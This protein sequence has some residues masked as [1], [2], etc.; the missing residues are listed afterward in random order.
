M[1]RPGTPSTKTT[2][3]RSHREDVLSFLDNLDSFEGSGNPSKDPASATASSSS[4]GGAASKA[5]GSSSK[6]QSS[7]VAAPSSTAGANSGE[8][9]DDPQAVLDFL[10]EIVANR[11]NRR[12]TTPSNNPA[13]SSTSTSKKAAS[14]GIAGTSGV[15]RSGSRN[16]LRDGE[17]SSSVGVT[18][19]R[20]A[21][22]STAAAAAPPRK[23]GESTRSLNTLNMTAASH[24][25]TAGQAAEKLQEAPVPESSA[26]AEEPKAGGWGWGSVWSQAS[27]VLQQARTVAEEQAKHLP[28]NLPTSISN[29]QSQLPVTPSVATSQ[30]QAGVNAATAQAQKWRSGMMNMLSNQLDI[31]KLRREITETGMKAMQ[32][33]MNAVAPPIAEHEVIQVNLSHDMLGYEGVETLVY[34][35]LAKVMEQVEGGDLVVNKGHVDDSPTAAPRQSAPA[36]EAGGE[37]E[38]EDER[39]L[40]TVEGLVEGYKLAEANLEALIKKHYKKPE[41]PS[42]ASSEKAAGHSRKESSLTIPVTICPVYMRIQPVLAPMPFSP[43]ALS[44]T[45]EADATSK[46]KTSDDL[47]LFFILILRDPTNELVHKTLTQS[48]PSKWLDIPFEENEWVEDIM[49]DVIRRG[50]EI[51]GE[52]YIKGRMHG[53]LFKNA[54]A[55]TVS[56][57]SEETEEEKEQRS[58]KMSESQAGVTA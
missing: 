36:A 1:S 26:A 17:A 46:L 39:S 37:G 47:H 32:D 10:D 28:K 30:A 58:E 7:K 20:V 54:K 52:E 55:E 56:E 18:S 34:R 11:D 4:A 31:D 16:T 40:N 42:S 15:V 5:G 12:S 8:N 14:S 57:E 33:I 27:N 43:Q 50:V 38:E 24:T 22:D 48:M 25:S 44:S 29:L 49:V 9:P 21:R 45:T 6:V 13:A 19:S 35:A 3:S 2:G 23:S 41:E 53:R 51:I